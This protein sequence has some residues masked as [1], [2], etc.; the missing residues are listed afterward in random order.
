MNRRITNVL[1]PVSALTRV[2]ATPDHYAQ[3]KRETESLRSHRGAAI[4]LAAEVE[5]TLQRAI[6]RN[7]H[8]DS[9]LTKE[10]FGSRGAL[11][12]FSAKTQI[13]QAVRI[14]GQ[15]T[16]ANLE[17]IRTVRNAFAHA[18]IPLSF[19]TTEIAKACAALT[20]PPDLMGRLIPTSSKLDK[21]TGRRR[22]KYVCQA[23]SS[24][25]LAHTFTGPV[26]YNP[27]AIKVPVQENYEVWARQEPLP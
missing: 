18:M 16:R 6:V 27:S 20:I 19:E 4:L 8:M 12:G 22:F 2:N 13:A 25:L 23:I 15:E 10:L 14:I 9:A 17:I 1:G 24:N 3:Y 5:S 7:L 21:L 11:A 26:G